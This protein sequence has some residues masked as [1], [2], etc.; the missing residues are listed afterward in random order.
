MARLSLK[1]PWIAF[2]LIALT[3]L[4]IA[5][6]LYGKQLIDNQRDP[7][8]VLLP[9]GYTGKVSI[10]YVQ[11]SAPPLPREGEY[12]VHQIPESGILKTSTA[13]P[14]YGIASD[15]YFYVDSQ[16]NRS[17]IDQGEFIHGE[18][19]GS[20]EGE[21]PVE[22]FFVGSKEQ[23]EAWVKSEEEKNKK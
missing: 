20:R 15:K 22:S 17:E 5:A 23:W 8:L 2:S 6:I 13:E 19:L 14:E 4:V 9:Q 1:K 10:L 3:L 18:G 12:V 11:E 7:S 21:P 16:G